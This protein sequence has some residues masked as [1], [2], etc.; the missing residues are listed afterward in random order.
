M[1]EENAAPD[2]APSLDDAMIAATEAAGRAATDAAAAWETLAGDECDPA[3]YEAV[4]KALDARQ[5]R[6]RESALEARAAASELSRAQRAA[7]TD[8]ME[9]SDSVKAAAT[10]AWRVL[11]RIRSAADRASSKIHRRGD[12]VSRDIECI[13]REGLE[14][15]ARAGAVAAAR[16]EVARRNGVVRDAAAVSRQTWD[17]IS[18]A[19]DA[20]KACAAALERRRDDRA[21]AID[22]DDERPAENGG[23]GVK[24]R[25]REVLIVAGIPNPGE[26]KKAKAALVDRA[27]EMLTGRSAD[28]PDNDLER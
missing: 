9:A 22:A 24:D 12:D 10:A 26:A 8:A 14:A 21:R 7:E 11:V 5:Q 6:C 27:Y 20:A 3:L 19:D 1:N 16:E 4:T 28:R 18:Q 17:A 13:E 15:R 2:Q 25:L 23:G